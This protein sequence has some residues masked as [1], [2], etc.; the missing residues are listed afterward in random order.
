[1]FD[2]ENTLGVCLLRVLFVAI[3]FLRK[4]QAADSGADTESEICNTP[5]CVHMANVILRNM[6]PNVHPCNDFYT[7]ACGNWEKYNPQPEDTIEWTVYTIMEKRIEVKTKELLLSVLRHT[8]NGQIYR[9]CLEKPSLA[10]SKPSVI[11]SYVKKN[12]T[13]NMRE[14]K[15]TKLFPSGYTI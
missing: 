7:Y 10:K 15:S 3:V 1:M 8:I 5:E 11:K 9:K 2:A 14:Y 6:N 12:K 4:G 13:H